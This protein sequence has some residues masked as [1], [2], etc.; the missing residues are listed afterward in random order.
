M[1]S[2]EPSRIVVKINIQ[3]SSRSTFNHRHDQHS[4]IVKTKAQPSQTIV[5]INIRPSETIVKINIPPS[6]TI[7]KI[8]IQPLKMIDLFKGILY[9]CKP[10]E[11]PP[12]IL[13]C[14][15]YHVE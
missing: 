4:T 10:A 8:N 7:V 9:Q 5:K 2:I 12:P 6:Q 1:T 13:T 14:K 11:L 3:P 15:N